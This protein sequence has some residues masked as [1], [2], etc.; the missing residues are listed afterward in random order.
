MTEIAADPMV[1]EVAQF[2]AHPPERVWQALTT[3]ELMAR[4]LMPPTG[5]A[6][7]VGTRFTFHGQPMMPSVGFS[8][9]IACEVIPVVTGEKLAI[10]WADAR[11]AKPAEWVVTWTP[12]PEGSGTRVV[13]RHSGFDPDDVVQQRLRS[14][15]P[16]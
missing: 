15:W 5:F 2:Y 6:P 11:S 9:E 14:G 1:I 7:V 8:G 4:W 12:H 13:L 3:P 10:S 16:L